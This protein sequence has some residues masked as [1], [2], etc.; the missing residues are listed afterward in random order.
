MRATLRFRCVARLEPAPCPESPIPFLDALRDPDRLRRKPSAPPLERGPI[1]APASDC[2]FPHRRQSAIVPQDAGTSRPAPGRYV[3]FV[4]LAQ[5]RCRA[6]DAKFPGPAPCPFPA[7][8]A[9]HR[10]PASP[11]LRTASRRRPSKRM[12]LS[13][14]R[15]PQRLPVQARQRRFLAKGEQLIDRSSGL[16][17]FRSWHKPRHRTI[18]P[19]D[20]HFFSLGN[21]VQKRRQAHLR[22]ER[23]DHGC[24]S[25]FKLV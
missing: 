3:S 12:R 7:D 17:R 2:P 8:A 13:P 6:P 22:L 5:V 10:F 20:K 4:P 1:L 24:S 25:P 11:R 19:G 9:A 14:S 23:S 21:F 18:S 16:F 15:I